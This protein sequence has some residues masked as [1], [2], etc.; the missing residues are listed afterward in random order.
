MDFEVIV[1]GG[2]PVGMMLASELALAKVKVCVLENLKETTPY[3]RAL[4]VHPRTLEIFDSRGLKEKIM[5]KGM[6]IS[7]GHFA[8]LDT[9]L[10][11]STLDSTSNYTV[12]IPQHD[13]EIELE[14][15]ARS[16]GVEIRRGEKVVSVRQDHQ[17]VEVVSVS[18]NGDS[19]LSAAY[20]VGADGGGSIVRKQANIPFVGKNSTFTALMGDVVLSNPP[21]SNVISRFSE[22][23]LVMVAPVNAQLHRVV[24][25]DPERMDVPKEEPVTLEELRSGLVRILGS[26]LG[27]TEPFWMSRFGNATLQVERYREGR[28]LLAGDAAHIHFPAGGQGLNVGLQEAMNLG[29]KLAAEIH[30]WAP[31]WLLDSYH[32]ERFPVSTAMLKNTEV[33]TLLF[34]FSPRMIELRNMLSSMLKIPES[35]YLLSTQISGFNVKYETDAKALP[36][37]LN[38]CRFTELKLRLENGTIRN[39]YE[40][41]HSGTFLLLH[42]ASDECMTYAVDWSRYK[43]VQVVRAT[44]AEEAPDWKDVHTALIRPD[45]YI[46]W[47][48]SKSEL[49]RMETIKKGISRWCGGHGIS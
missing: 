15:W 31:D 6:P 24:M 38:G 16:L 13:T 21:E 8:V 10:D 33:Q 1:V 47:A 29:W 39:A 7:K 36:H 14:K 26:D 18:S 49:G 9:P 48:V 4:T 35:N 5:S 32:E 11:F 41:F 28:V 45:G 20:V 37:A 23:G 22:R 12:F 2:G 19:V 30:G 3:S 42:L 46:A 27:I 34:E 43:H 17:G 25:V 44:L 40:L